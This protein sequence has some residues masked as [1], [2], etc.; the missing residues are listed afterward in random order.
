MSDI[1]IKMLAEVALKNIQIL[2]EY[3]NNNKNKIEDRLRVESWLSMINRM[4]NTG[5][6]LDKEDVVMKDS[7]GGVWIASKLKENKKDDKKYEKKD[8]R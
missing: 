6:S 8:D 4:I 2:S 3:K 7:F 1:Q 5:S